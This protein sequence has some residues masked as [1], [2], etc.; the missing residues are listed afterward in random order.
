MDMNYIVSEEGRAV[1]VAENRLITG[2]VVPA[3]LSAVRL[4][5][6]TVRVNWFTNGASGFDLE[7]TATLSPPVN[8]QFWGTPT[9]NGP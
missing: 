3:Y 2:G 7:Y 1:A 6:D 8:W 5:P 4:D 9:L